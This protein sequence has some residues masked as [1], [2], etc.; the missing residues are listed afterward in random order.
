MSA[1]V[2]VESCNECP[3]YNFNPFGGA[4]WCQS[5]K[6]ELMNTSIPDRCPYK[7]KETRKCE[8]NHSWERNPDRMGGQFTDDEINNHGRQGC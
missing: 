5:G 8:C 1:Y 7:K 2:K 4:D 3:H 6:F